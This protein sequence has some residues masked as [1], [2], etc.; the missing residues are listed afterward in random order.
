MTYNTGLYE[1]LL[2]R[3]V[4]QKTECSRFTQRGQVALCSSTTGYICTAV[5]LVSARSENESFVD[6]TSEGIIRK[7]RLILQYHWLSITS[8][9]F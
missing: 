9:L 2:M 4:T 7:I 6:G 8:S 1:L 5:D 3:N